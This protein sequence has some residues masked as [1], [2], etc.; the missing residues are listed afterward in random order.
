MSVT[1][2][3]WIV[4]PLHLNLPTTYVAKRSTGVG[5][6]VKS[7]AHVQQSSKASSSVSLGGGIDGKWFNWWWVGAHVVRVVAHTSV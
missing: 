3:E 5:R 2:H 4:E 7:A 6:F 1:V